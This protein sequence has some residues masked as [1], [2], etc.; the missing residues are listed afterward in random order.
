VLSFQPLAANAPLK[1]AQDVSLVCGFGNFGGDLFYGF[2]EQPLGLSLAQYTLKQH[3]SLAPI[4][5]TW[6]I[7]TRVIIAA[8]VSRAGVPRLQPSKAAP[9]MADE[10]MMI[11]IPTRI[12]M[13]GHLGL[14]SLLSSAQC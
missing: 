13:K 3:S 14:H 9:A 2:P 10:V 5:K 12:C 11:D 7:R 4:G 6:S 1:V 8:P